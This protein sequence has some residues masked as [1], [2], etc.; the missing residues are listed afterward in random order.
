MGTYAGKMSSKAANFSKAALIFGAFGFGVA[1]ST[2]Y[3]FAKEGDYEAVKEAIRN[4]LDDE[5]WDDGS[6]G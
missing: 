6:W 1:A 5:K 4:I 2:Q 3:A